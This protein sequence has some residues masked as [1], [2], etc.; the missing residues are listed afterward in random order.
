MAVLSIK[1][2]IGDR[3]YPMKVDESEEEMVRNAGR[4]LNEKIKQYKSEYGIHDRQDILAM[5]AFDTIIDKL[6]LSHAKETD[7]SEISEKIS[8]L[9][10]LITKA[11][12][13]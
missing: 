1:I 5:V 2:R 6:K 11:L 9:D 13:D 3:D 4:L 7:E 12:S 10:S 8:Y